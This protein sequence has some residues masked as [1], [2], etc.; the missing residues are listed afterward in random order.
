L[1][2][3]SAQPPR[4]RELREFPVRVRFR[5]TLRMC[6]DSVESPCSVAAFVVNSK[7]HTG[8]RPS[9][10]LCV[11]PELTRCVHKH[12]NIIETSVFR[13]EALTITAGGRIVLACCRRSVFGQDKAQTNI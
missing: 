12:G 4:E 3:F 7:L 9:V 2:V 11:R 8:P 6:T 10:R 5:V 1:A 13:H